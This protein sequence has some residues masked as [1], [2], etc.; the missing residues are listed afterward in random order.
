MKKDNEVRIYLKERKKGCSQEI[1]AA[2]AGMGVRT[3][4]KYEHAGTLPSQ[5]KKERTHKTRPDAF[6]GDWP[7]VLAEIERDSA[8]QAKTLFGLLCLKHPG[9]YQEGQL[10]T[11]QR[12][13][14]RWRALFGPD[15]NVMFEQVHVPGRMAQSDFTEMDKLAITI[16]GIPFE[17]LL[18]HVVLTYSNHEAVKVC[19]SESFESLAEG[20]ETCLWLIGG[21]P[22][23]HRTDNLSAAVR[24]L[25]DEGRRDFTERYA[26]LMRHYD[27]TPTRN[28][29]G[30]SH[31]NGDV[32]KSHDLF[33]K[34][35][36]QALRVRG[37]RDFESREQYEA[38]LQELVRQRN[39]TRTKR[40]AEDFA[41]LKPL[42][43]QVLAPCREEQVT[44]SRFSTVRVS[45]NTYSVPSRLIGCRLRVKLRSETL[46]M[47]LAGTL[48]LT[49]PRLKGRNQHRI[50]YRHVI[51]SLARKPGAFANYRYRD[52]FF[53][54]TVFRRAYDD[55]AA[56]RPEKGDG[57]Y[58]RILHL[59]ASVS[60]ADVEAALEL[61]L[62]A[63]ERFDFF[64][65][66]DL[67]NGPKAAPGV[68]EVTTPELD[69]TVYDRFLPSRGA[70]AH[71]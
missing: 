63:G 38:Y 33:K 24:R 9:R 62:D 11:L 64:T 36:D 3:A 55:L 29:P 15:L 49:V 8:L 60:E 5:M 4:R 70:H 7:W 34:A 6:E 35:L 47:Y 17:H 10:R 43:M 23:F 67:V 39:L 59:A 41:A 12:R 69:L 27:M 56:R 32:E 68:P 19:F 46:E 57:D 16:A 22:E 30:E 14:E 25:D 1:A 21:A 53:P 26:G 37:S 58:L 52:E 13:I 44:V 20:I 42:P 71:A 54:T 65:V 2:R 40:F 61:L 48:V 66:R 51:W 31:Q 45:Y 28:H 50:D 18:Y